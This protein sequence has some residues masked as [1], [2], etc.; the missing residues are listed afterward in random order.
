MLAAALL[1]CGFAAS[2]V[3]SAAPPRPP[4]LAGYRQISIDW[5][6]DERFAGSLHGQRLWI[7][8]G[9][10]CGDDF[11]V[12]PFSGDH[13]NG[14]PFIH[15]AIPPH[16]PVNILLEE[17]PDRRLHLCGPNRYGATPE[18]FGWRVICLCTV[19]CP[20]LSL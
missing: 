18:L 19:D 8:G 15:I 14:G 12:A 3:H 4:K 13:P 1:L 6:G 5:L 11:L 10:A 2:V 20:Q 16:T 7:T 17:L 9:V